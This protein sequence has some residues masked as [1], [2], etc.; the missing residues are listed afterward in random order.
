MVPSTEPAASDRS[1]L[2]AVRLASRASLV[3][4]SVVEIARS[5]S[6]AT[7]KKPS[8]KPSRLPTCSSAARKTVAASSIRAAS[9]S[10][11]LTRANI[12]APSSHLRGR[13]QI[14]DSVQRPLELAVVERDI[15]EPA[16][17]IV[18]V[19]GHVEMAVAGEIEEDGA[20]LA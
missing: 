18:V 10:Y 9:I 11:V 6:G 17:E 1:R 16:G 2:A 14:R 5:S 13:G 8:M 7:K 19:R 20:L 15:L 4:Q 12:C 3:L